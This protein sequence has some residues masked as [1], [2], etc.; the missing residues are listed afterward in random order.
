MSIACRIRFPSEFPD[1]EKNYKFNDSYTVRQAIQEISSEYKVFPN[2]FGLCH[3]GGDWLSPDARLS[4]FNLTIKTVLEF[5]KTYFLSV[6]TCFNSQANYRDRMLCLPLLEPVSQ[7]YQYIGRKF[8][9]PEASMSEYELAIEGKWDDL[10]TDSL[11]TIKGCEQKKLIFKSTRPKRAFDPREFVIYH[12]LREKELKGTL[13]SDSSQVSDSSDISLDAPASQ[14][15]LQFPKLSGYITKLNKKKKWDRFFCIVLNQHMIFYNNQSDEKPTQIISL[16][17]YEAAKLPPDPKKK[18]SFAIEFTCGEDKILT[19]AENAQWHTLWYD[20]IKSTIEDATLAGGSSSSSS[21]SSSAAPSNEASENLVFGIPLEDL[22]ARHP[23]LEVPPIVTTC[24]DYIDERALQVEGI[25]RLSGSAT[26]IEKYKN[27]Y[28]SGE[29]VDFSNESDPH[30]V[31]GLLKLWFRELPDPVLTWERY[32]RFLTAER[33]KNSNLRLRYFKHL[34]K[35]LPSWNQNLLGVL[36]TFLVKVNRF[37]AVNK[38]PIHNL[39]TVFGPNILKKKGANMF[40]MVEDTPQINNIVGLLITNEEYFFR[41][42]SLPP[43]SE[44]EEDNIVAARSLYDYVPDNGTADDM[45]LKKN[46]IVNIIYQGP[47]EGWWVGEV[48]DKFGRFPGSYVQVLTPDQW[49]KVKRKLKFKA[50]MIQLRRQYA[51][52][53]QTI[54]KLNEEIEKQRAIRLTVDQKFSLLKQKYLNTQ[55]RLNHL[56]SAP[57]LAPLP[58]KLELYAKHLGD[59]VA[60]QTAITELRTELLAHFS[61][62]DEQL[63]GLYDP[64]DKKKKVDKKVEKTVLDIQQAL[65]NTRTVMEAEHNTR[66]FASDTE[67]STIIELL[68][69]IRFINFCKTN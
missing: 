66:A 47:A 15:L 6:T 5:K 42:G 3:E 18:I 53:Q 9:V 25:F 43:E 48:D 33:I 35:S 38:M 17:K 22:M 34:I 58:D 24:I 13:D 54:A 62:L 16:T 30:A 59:W 49:V 10:L 45:T 51:D 56:F 52:E 14:L 21:S 65:H 7:W 8:L 67:R 60:S 4:T 28:N 2:L 61:S 46:D 11:S 1:G 63:T 57:P 31:S 50:E 27:L 26:L 37:N 20:A 64:K 29:D 12:E 19:K 36:V 23:G 41:G 44:Q 40:E 39:A 69:F 55:T 68:D 32:P